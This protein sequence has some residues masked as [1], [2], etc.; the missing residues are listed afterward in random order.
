MPVQVSCYVLST[1]NLGLNETDKTSVTLGAYSL[2]K[3]WMLSIVTWIKCFW[4]GVVINTTRVKYNVQFRA[5]SLEGTTILYCSY[6]RTLNLM[7]T[8]EFSVSNIPLS[9][10]T[11]LSPNLLALA[12]PTATV[13]PRMSSSFHWPHYV[14]VL[15]VPSFFTFFLTQFSFCKPSL[16]KHLNILFI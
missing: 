12:T 1:G 3:E 9:N 4:N 13:W 5:Y 16:L 14:L 15:Y 6:D 7:T 10:K 2:I 8:S 11:F